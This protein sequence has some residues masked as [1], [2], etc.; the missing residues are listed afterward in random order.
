MMLSD[1]AV[2]LTEFNV[3]ST[4]K[5]IYGVKQTQRCCT[6]IHSRYAHHINDEATVVLLS[7]VRD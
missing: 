3:G 1:R 7:H 2:H 6:E 5:T 4:M